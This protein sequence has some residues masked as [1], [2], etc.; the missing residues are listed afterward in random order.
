MT[1]SNKVE[2]V[3]KIAKMAH[4]QA[5]ENIGLVTFIE[6][7][8][9]PGIHGLFKAGEGHVPFLI[10]G[11]LLERLTMALNRL[12]D[13]PGNRKGKADPSTSERDSLPVAFAL[14]DD[15]KVRKAATARGGAKKMA[16]A[17]AL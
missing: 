1:V 2:R 13:P 6:L 14:L 4:D 9:R 5:N 7:G 16:T 17:I 8:N 3:R 10:R 15:P 12:F 11:A